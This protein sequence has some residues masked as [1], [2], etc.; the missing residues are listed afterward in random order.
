MGKYLSG[1]GNNLLRISFDPWQV[2][3]RQIF[4]P[5]SRLLISTALVVV[6][7]VS[8]LGVTGVMHWKILTSNEMAHTWIAKT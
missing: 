2:V 3:P 7:R 6:S 1:T 5:D 8:C 4:T